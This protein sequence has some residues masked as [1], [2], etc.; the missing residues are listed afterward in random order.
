MVC[1]LWPPCQHVEVA[2]QPTLA[3]IIYW[4]GH[5]VFQTREK[6]FDDGLF[7]FS[8]FEIVATKPGKQLIVQ[9]VVSL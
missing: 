1:L 8:F 7:C 3:S 9:L 4:H 2:G 6:T 5:L